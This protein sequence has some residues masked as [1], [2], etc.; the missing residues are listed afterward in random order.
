MASKSSYGI[1]KLAPGGADTN[2]RTVRLFRVSD[3][4]SGFGCL[5]LLFLQED[6]DTRVIYTHEFGR[7][8][9][10]DIYFCLGVP[11]TRTAG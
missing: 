1:A 8:K 2:D 5:R 4:E 7:T 9:R 3:N 10:G 6:G 11:P